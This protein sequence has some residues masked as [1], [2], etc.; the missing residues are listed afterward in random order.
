MRYA[1]F[2]RQPMKALEQ[3]DGIGKQFLAKN[4]EPIQLK[5]FFY[6]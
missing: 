6:S 5:T 4:T 1:W 3:N 2:L